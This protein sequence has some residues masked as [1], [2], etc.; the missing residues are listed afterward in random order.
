FRELPPTYDAP[1]AM[2]HARVKL[3][4]IESAGKKSLHDLDITDESGK[5]H[6]NAADKF[7]Q[8]NRYVEI[9]TPHLEK[10]SGRGTI[11]VA[12]MG[13]GK[14]YLT[15][16]LYDHIVNNLKIPGDVT[17]VEYRADMVDLCNRI[18]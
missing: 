16:A 5:V 12:D 17:G 2:D 18:A 13:A 6:K 15:F 4:P 10:F 14:G 9:L 3:R 11:R 1:P 8:I 7:R